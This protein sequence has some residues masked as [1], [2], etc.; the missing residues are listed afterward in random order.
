MGH[1]E[2]IHGPCGEANKNSPCMEN[3]TCTKHFPKQFHEKTI[4]T[5]DGYPMFKR[6]EDGVTIEKKWCKIGQ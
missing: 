2:K 4:Q 3:G 1:V 6:S 5:Y